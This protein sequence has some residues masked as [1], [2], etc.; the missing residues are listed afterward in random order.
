M[1]YVNTSKDELYPF[2]F[3]ILFYVFNFYLKH[4]LVTL[5]MENL[6]NVL[7][8]LLFIVWARE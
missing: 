3:C 1:H 8:M 7:F 4:F 2:T 6:F 5:V